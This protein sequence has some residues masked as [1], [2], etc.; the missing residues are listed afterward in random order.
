MCVYIQKINVSFICFVHVG[1]SFIMCACMFGVGV[2]GDSV[3]SV[4]VLCVC[5]CVV[6][7][8]AWVYVV[9]QY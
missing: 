1:V 6:V 2:I 7:W 9:S 8:R 3:K 4:F 5:V